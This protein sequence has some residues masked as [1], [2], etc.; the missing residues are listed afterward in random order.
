MNI[1]NIDFQKMNGLIP[2][3]IQDNVSEEVYML[4]Y[5]NKESLL[6]TFETGM[7]NFWSRSRR[8]IWMKG[9]QSGNVLKV[10][11]IFVDC[12]ADTLLIKV[13]LLG[14]CVCHTGNRTCFNEKLSISK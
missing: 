3:I 1:K 6:K 12:D 10:K 13:D 5:M 14:N 2:T 9:E 8:K 11:D 7:L 4:G